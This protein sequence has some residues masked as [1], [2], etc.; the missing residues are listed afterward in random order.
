MFDN[1]KDNKK[2]IFYPVTLEEIEKV[3]KELKI[4]FPISLK[5][6]YLE[7]GYGFIHSEVGNINRIMHPLSVR[8]FRLRQNDFE[9]YPD[10][11]IYDEFEG[12]KLIFFEGNEASLL[13]VGF[14]SEEGK[15]FYYDEKL[16]DNFSD[17]IIKINEDDTFYYDAI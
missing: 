12:N 13:S 9:Y 1:L 6:F 5:T 15:V 7:V 10:I 4:K 11:E 2:N 17:F 16:T 8:D 3:E 14:N